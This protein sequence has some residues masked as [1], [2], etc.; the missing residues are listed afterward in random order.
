MNLTH[1]QASEAQLLCHEQRQQRLHP[2]RER[3]Q[4]VC[5]GLG[6]SPETGL[7]WCCC[8]WAGLSA[9]TSTMLPLTPWERLHQLPP[10]LSRGPAV[11]GRASPGDVTYHAPRGACQLC[12]W[13]LPLLLG[14]YMVLFGWPL[15]SVAASGGLDE[16]WGYCEGRNDGLG[17]AGD[18]G[19]T[20]LGSHP[21]QAAWSIIRSHRPEP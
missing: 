1:V 18:L 7:S 4:T 14:S 16:A 6:S 2:S 3:R 19:C 8:H 13:Q 5:T 9:G 10:A 17:A 20:L 12:C 21:P 15:P 11:V